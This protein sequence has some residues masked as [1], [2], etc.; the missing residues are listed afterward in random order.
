MLTWFTRVVKDARRLA[1]IA[2]SR[3]YWL[4]NIIY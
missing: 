3:E 2:N 4:K 1:A